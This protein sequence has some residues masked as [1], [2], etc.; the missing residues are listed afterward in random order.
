MQADVPRA[1]IDPQTQVAIGLDIGDGES[2]LAWIDTSQAGS[3][4]TYR[5]GN[6]E[7]SILTAL[8]RSVT[9]GRRLIGEDAIGA[10]AIQ[11][12][13]NVKRIRRAR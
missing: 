2:S 9:D 3:A 5:R 8:A 10:D 13:V 11:F 6:G 1:G 12:A 4:T 7:R